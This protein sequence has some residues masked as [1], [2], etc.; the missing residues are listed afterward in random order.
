MTIELVT[1]TTCD[2]PAA[3]RE[4]HR[5]HFVPINIQFGAETYRENVTLSPDEFY[6]RIEEEGM[7]P[8]TS[9]PSVG[10]FADVYNALAGEGVEI[11]SAHV[12]AKL[13]GTYQSACMAAERVAGAV[14]VHVLDS[15]AGS[16][17]L[18]WMLVEASR[19][20]AAG[21]TAAD[22]VAR[23][24]AQRPRLTIYFAVDD[25]KFARMSGR[26]GKLAGVIGSVLNIKPVIGLQEGLIDVRERV[27]SRKAAVRRILDL[28]R[29]H[30]GD[31][32]VRVG[33]VHAQAPDRAADLL[34]QAERT[35]NVQESFL[36][37]VAISLAVHFGPG[38]LGLITY[39]ATDR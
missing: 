16:A 24:E 10:E 4:E 2:L 12:T 9:Q 7:L 39:P 38:T 35:L 36:T 17:G 25:L 31:A 5:I 22:I 37:D 26:V 6:R 30:V 29:E 21:H 13:S 32:P 34:A 23:L 3:M 14:K 27:R 28:T 15:M 19:M 20:R 8:Q 11:I 18:G 1:D 33:V